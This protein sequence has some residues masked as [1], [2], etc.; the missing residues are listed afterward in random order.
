MMA[1]CQLL[2][3]TSSSPCNQITHVIPDSL[4][5]NYIYSSSNQVFFK[6]YV[7]KRCLEW[8][9]I[10]VTIRKAQSLKSFSDLYKHDLSSSL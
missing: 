5:L 6:S 2:Q 1:Y 4:I 10:R 8:N 3:K 9:K 7:Y